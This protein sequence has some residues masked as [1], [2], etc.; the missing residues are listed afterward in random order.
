MASGLGKSGVA[1]EKILTRYQ[2]IPTYTGTLDEYIA[3][4]GYRALPKA[5][6]EFQPARL[7]R[8][9]RNRACGDAAGRDSPAD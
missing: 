7:S 4:G 5:L 1:F 2:E 3:H 9:S 8:K 6:R